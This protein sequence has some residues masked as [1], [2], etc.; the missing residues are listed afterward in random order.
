MWALADGLR[1]RLS[2]VRPAELS[3]IRGCVVNSV[4]VSA[5]RRSDAELL[6][7]S[8]SDATA[9]AAFYDR[10]E[11]AVVGY[12]V[13]RVAD[14]ELVADLAAEVFAAAL[15]GA[16]R[17]RPSQPTAASWLFAIAH[18]T[19]ATSMRRRRVEA[20]ARLRLGIRD[21]V[22]FDDNELDR[23]E[24][25]ASDDSWLADLL[26]RLPREQAEAIRARVLDERSYPDIAG[27]LATSE[28]VVRK[29]VSRG[30]ATLRRELNKEKR[31]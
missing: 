5:R 8:R 31:P 16:A 2:L 19:L 26:S 18:N 7:E 20:R 30:L 3:Q 12:L 11:T 17:Y 9:F 10:Y 22:S 27:E 28:L 29:R 25:L 24:A 4:V 21:A 23:V 15:S 1:A 13:R 6:R 14:P